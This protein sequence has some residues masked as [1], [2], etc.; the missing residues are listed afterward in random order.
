MTRSGSSPWRPS[1]SR[2]VIENIVSYT[3]RGGSPV[4]W[5]HIR[6]GC[7]DRGGVAYLVVLG[8][9]K[10]VVAAL[11]HDAGPGMTHRRRPQ[12][13]TMT[14]AIGST[15]TIVSPLNT[16]SH[17]AC[18]I[19]CGQWWYGS[20]EMRR[21]GPNGDPAKGDLK[22]PVT[23]R[24]RHW[25]RSHQSS[26]QLLPPSCPNQRKEQSLPGASPCPNFDS[27]EKHHH[28]PPLCREAQPPLSHRR[29]PQARHACR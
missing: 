19:S 15:L 27:S 28:R 18:K 3:D 1:Q 9:V 2:S 16:T 4:S 5:D 20:V 23:A 26:R 10:D 17:R 29:R 25:T 24:C 7:R 14:G 21:Y 13:Q 12:G 6:T 8:V 22:G 11:V